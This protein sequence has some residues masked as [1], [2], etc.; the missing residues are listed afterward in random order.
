MRRFKAIFCL[1]GLFWWYFQRR[2]VSTKLLPN[3]PPK[4]SRNFTGSSTGCKPESSMPKSSYDTSWP[5]WLYSCFPFM[6]WSLFLTVIQS[7]AK[8]E[9]ILKLIQ[10]KTVN[11]RR[12]S[13]VLRSVVK[14]KNFWW[15]RIEVILLSDVEEEI[16]NE[17]IE[18]KKVENVQ[19]EPGGRAKV[20]LKWTLLKFII[21]NYPIR[22]PLT[23][24]IRAG[25]F[26][27]NRSKIDFR[28]TKHTWILKVPLRTPTKIKF[29]I[30]WYYLR[31]PEMK[32]SKFHRP[33][34]GRK[35]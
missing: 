5:P 7:W 13:K 12:S 20:S 26:W 32:F 14:R 3:T 8:T 29:H 11:K 22:A 6:S 27:P 2:H 23:V 19:K 1:E 9:R 34:M 10:G 18:M 24:T 4:F 30:F 16:E 25:H 21:G 17:S 35:L 28:G 33:E 15:Y 31:K